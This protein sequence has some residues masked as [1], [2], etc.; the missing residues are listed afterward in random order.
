M[1]PQISNTIKS[2]QAQIHKISK[3][4]KYLTIDSTKTIVHALVTSRLDNL[5]SLLYKLP[6]YE[7]ERLQKVQNNAARL[8][9]KQSRDKD[10]TPILK[11]LHWLPV[12]RRIEYKILLLTFKCLH[13][14]APSYLSSLLQWY[15]P[16]RPLRSAS[17][18]L[19]QE[20]K[21]SKIFGDRAFFTCAPL[22][23]KKLPLDLRRC[24]SLTSF[25]TGLKTHL[26]KQHFKG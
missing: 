17:E 22:L 8:I 6:D 3:I 9:F 7:K 10:I 25:K 18:L 21:S 2:C 13:K 11:T 16:P 19:L 14:L 26:F 20:H 24:E 1:K 15:T 12:H 23:W 5:N 4:R